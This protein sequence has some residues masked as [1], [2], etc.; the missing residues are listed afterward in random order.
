LTQNAI[1]LRQT[2]QQQLKQRLEA[3]AAIR[4]AREKAI[5]AKNSPVAEAVEADAEAAAEN[6]E[7]PEAEVAETVVENADEAA[8]EA[9]ATEEVVAEASEAPEA[10]EEAAPEA[11]AERRRREE[12]RGVSASSNSAFKNRRMIFS[13]GPLKAIGLIRKTHGFKGGLKVEKYSE[14]TLDEKESVFIHMDGKPVPFFIQEVAD[15]KDSAIVFFE[16]VTSEESARSFCGKEI[17]IPTM[18][19]SVEETNFQGYR[20]LDG[21]E[22]LIG[23]IHEVLEYPQ[24]LMLRFKEHQNLIPLAEDF[25]LH[26]DHQSRVIQ[27][28]L[29]DGLLNLND[30]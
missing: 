10:T 22:G 12:R 3:E 18:E 17:L 13:P 6:A 29:P 27:L 20:C 21:N 9:E 11:E 4:E 19:A 8:P 30:V 16:D 24:Q 25:I 7:A 2:R 1:S 26:I 5:M 14:E 23:T 28:D 15:S